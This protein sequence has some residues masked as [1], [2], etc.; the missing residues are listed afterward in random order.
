MKA[1]DLLLDKVR[2]LD[3]DAA[4]V[5]EWCGKSIRSCE[6][7][8]D[9]VLFLD[10][11][12]N[13]AIAEIKHSAIRPIVSLSKTHPQLVDEVIEEV[14]RLERPTLKKIA[15]ITKEKIRRE[16]P[17]PDGKY[18]VIVVD[19]PWEFEGEYDKDSRRSVPQYPTMTYEQIQNIKIPAS[20][21]CVLWLWT[22][23]LDL[24]H[25]WDIAEGWGFVVKSIL[26]WV[27]NKRGMGYWLRGK[28]EHCLLGIKGSPIWKNE[29]YSTVIF[30][31]VREHSRKP[32]EFY[33]LVDDICLGKRIDMFSREKREGWDQWGDETDKF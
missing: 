1:C 33:D 25:A 24:R 14:K 8:V 29:E 10:K 9:D 4:A 23:N 21:D 5:H 32:D 30:G 13:S 20:D 18:D 19:P 22:T 27:K 15:A 3:Y 28:S 31:D 17:L 12:L 2:K 6:E 26:T 16:T 7:L 11:H